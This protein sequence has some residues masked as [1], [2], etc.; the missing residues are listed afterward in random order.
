M[1][2]GIVSVLVTD[3]NGCTKTSQIHVFQPDELVYTVVKLNDESCSG[4][5]SACDGNLRLSASG[6]IGSY[7]F[8]WLDLQDNFVDSASSDSIAIA[9]SLC[10]GFYQFVVKDE[11]G[12]EGVSSGS[13]IIPPVEIIAGSPV[14]SVINTSPGAISNNILCHGDTSASL[15]VSNP[16]SS[17]FYNWYVNG[18]FSASGTDVLLPAGEIYVRAVQS[19][20]YTNSDTL[21][22]FQPSILSID[23]QVENINCNGGTNGK[24]SIEASGGFPNYSYLWMSLTDTLIGTTYLENLSSGVYTLT[25][26]D[27]NDCKRQFDID[28]NEPSPLIIN[29]NVKDVNCYGASNGSAELEIEGGTTPYITNWQGADSTALSAGTY[30]VI[31]TDANTCSDTIDVIINEPDSVSAYFDSDQLPFTASASGGTPPYLYEWLY[32]GNTQSQSMTFMPQLDGEYTLVAI[33]ANGCQGRLMNT[34]NKNVSVSEFESNEVLI[35]PN[36]AKDNFIIQMTHNEE[37]TDYLFKLID[38]RGRI[39]KK[40]S[41]RKSIQIDRQDLAAGIYVIHISSGSKFM[42]QKIIFSDN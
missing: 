17:Y 25:L 14:E 24:I 39:L 10:S 8:S 19:T 27:N 9:S 28:L 35:F 42:Q 3:V 30:P 1:T 40:E 34:Y 26:E 12:C 21:T 7:E 23:E 29:K 38:S 22:I 41:F 31:V 18:Q 11:R 4:Q 20:C 16:N 37:N 5:V 13:G 32:F 6:G 33:D 2:E 36:P 15:S